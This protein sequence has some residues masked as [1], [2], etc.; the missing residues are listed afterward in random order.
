MSI[1]NKNKIKDFF[2]Y[3]IGQLINIGSPL[4]VMPFI[5]AKCGQDNFGKVGV[6][7]SL[8]MILNGFIDYGS[9]I[10]GVKEIS[11]NRVNIKH[12]E[13]KFNA[14]YLS[15]LI[16][17]VAVLSF[18]TVLIFFIPFLAK[19]KT[20]YFLSLFV[21]LGQFINPIWFFQGVENFKWI[22]IVNFISMSLNIIITLMN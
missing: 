10:N 22:S 2:I 14:I 13:L 9:Y 12:L 6:G 1:F 17:L 3:G 19:D 4:F 16:L 8:A 7:L 21:V 20:L 11:V 15:K 18:I 5:I